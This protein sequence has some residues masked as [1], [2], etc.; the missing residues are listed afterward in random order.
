MCEARRAV[1]RTSLL[2]VISWGVAMSASAQ[3]APRPPGPPPTATLTV[4]EAVRE[5]IDHNL[6]LAAERYSV[7]VARAR[8]VTARLRPNPVFTYSAMLPDSAIYDNDV[9]PF[10][11]VFRMDV[12]M[13]GGGK[14]AR[15]IEVAQQAT[16][17]AELQLLNTIR[18]IMLDVQGAFVDVVLAKENAALA[19]ESLDAFNA[20][21]Q[22]NT[23]RV[24]TGDLSQVEL[25]RSRL[26]ALQFQNDVRQRESKLAI[27][28]HKLKTAI[29]RTGPD[30]VDVTGE[31][32][33]EATPAAI[34]TV[35]RLALETRPDLQALRHDEAR[36]AADL[37][38]QIAQGKIDYTVSGEFHRQQ[39]PHDIVGNQYGLYVSV[40]LPIFNR[41]QGEV[42]RARGESRQIDAR[43][44]ALEADIGREVQAAYE[45]YSAARDI[46]ATIETQMLTQARDVRATT[47]YSYRQ[48]E[49][50]FVEFLDAVRA[51]N[52]T[53]QSYNE[54]RAEYARSLYALDSISGKVTP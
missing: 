32:R 16:T 6:T 51:F 34:E 11:N 30:A 9:N 25:A 28:R 43:I 54:A 52:D 50:S 42:E 10:E 18:T 46:V 26:A 23:E 45:E 7:S 35:A 49:A 37:R 8:I 41:N 17:V 19:R 47:E 36:S 22:V 33:R 44:R 27:A 2:C 20:L 14:R 5:A 15:R 21:V 4:D 1:A 38:L 31:L 48:G 39:A 3:P 53:M 12:V 13:E 24:R 29:G 40:P